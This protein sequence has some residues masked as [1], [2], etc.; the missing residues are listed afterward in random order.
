MAQKHYG[1]EILNPDAATNLSLHRTDLSTHRTA[2][3]TARS[4]M[5][6]ERTL[7]S[8]LR[9]CLALMSFGI[10]L[11][12]FSIVLREDHT[13]MQTQHQILLQ[14]EYV[15]IGMVFLGMVILV[16]SLTRF[17]KVHKEIE[18]DTYSSPHRAI[19]IIVFSVIILGGLS[20]AWMLFN[21][22]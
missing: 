1:I 15:G 6:N 8:Y 22:G 5:S 21:R 9:T 10:T 4:H 20:A 12:R 16:W 19:M 13:K 17:N 3:S 18:S 14:T 2:M 7:L 11:N